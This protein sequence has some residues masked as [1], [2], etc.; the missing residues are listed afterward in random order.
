MVQKGDKGSVD[1]VTWYAAEGRAGKL[2]QGAAAAAAALLE[3][4]VTDEQ[5]VAL[6][7]VAKEA[8]M[9]Q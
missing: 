7:A 5:R 9:Q 8:C 1:G 6:A 2:Q 3:K 4:G